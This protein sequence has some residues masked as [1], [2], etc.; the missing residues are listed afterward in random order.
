MLDQQTAD[1]RIPV[2]GRRHR[3]PSRGGVGAAQCREV[4]QSGIERIGIV[5]EVRI[6]LAQERD[7]LRVSGVDADAWAA[8][9]PVHQVLRHANLA[10]LAALRFDIDGPR[11]SELAELL[12]QRCLERLL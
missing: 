2:A 11:G 6:L 12:A 3:A 9:H 10:D 7:P 5:D 4:L 1:Q 8:P